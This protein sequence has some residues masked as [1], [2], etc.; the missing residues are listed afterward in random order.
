VPREIL[1]TDRAYNL[2]LISCV[3]NVILS[4][5]RKMSLVFLLPLYAEELF[6]FFFCKM[7]TAA[8]TSVR[9]EDEI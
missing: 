1:C 3:H 9:G 8:L 4:P 5:A 2:A 7:G 6:S